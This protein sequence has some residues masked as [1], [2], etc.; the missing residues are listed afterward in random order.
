[1]QL[2]AVWGW[3][4]PSP[5][6]FVFDD[7][8]RLME[9]ASKNHL[10]VILSSI[11]AVQPYWI[12]REV[13]GSEMITNMGTPVVSSNRGECHFGITPGGCTDH[14][15]V[16]D[17]MSRFI[18]ALVTRYRSSDALAG[19]D[20]WN[21]LR[22]NVQADGLVCY[23]RN[24]VNAYRS[25]LR[26]THGRAR[27]ELVKS[28]DPN[29]PA[30]LHGGAPTVLHGSDAYPAATALHRGNDWAFADTI[31]GIGC[32]S[33][34]LWQ[35]MDEADY[36]ARIDY[37]RSAAREKRIWLSEVQ[38][39]R[40]SSGFSLH[41]PVPGAAQQRRLWTGLGDGADTVLFW[42]WRDE[43]FGRESGGFGMNGRDGAAQDRLSAMRTAGSLLRDHGPLFEGY[44][45]DRPRVGVFFSPQSYYLHWAQDGNAIAPMRAVQ[46]Y[47]R[48]CVKTNTGAHGVRRR[49]QTVRSV[50]AA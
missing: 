2:W 12:H 9:L 7:Y 31:E 10:H 39:G 27:Y 41:K 20:V 17:R 38:G 46:G 35:G 44:R 1:M 13:P 50:E 6:E 48:A 4:E 29:H 21:E 43:V 28:L 3:I 32:S 47:A 22:W 24:T 49:H 37:V 23:C 30:T 15:V 40:A 45:I 5:D 8:D 34:P 19:W 26:E 16:W 42:C 18:S 25:W 14:P 11:A 33:F 36:I